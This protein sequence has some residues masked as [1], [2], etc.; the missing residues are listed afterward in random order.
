[1]GLSLRACA[2]TFALCSLCGG[3]WKLDKCAEFVYVPLPTII[4]LKQVLLY[5]FPDLCKER[6]LPHPT[7]TVFR[8]HLLPL[9][10]PDEAELAGLSNNRESPHWYAQTH[11]TGGLSSN[12]LTD[13]LLWTS[14]L[15]S[16]SGFVH[17]PGGWGRGV[18]FLFLDLGGHSNKM[19]YIS[20]AETDSFSSTS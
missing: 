3:R 11:L 2:H 15:A 14:N 10:Q 18:N 5:S 17:D 7:P 19:K 8:F 6:V 9:L 4:I 20:S 16:V 12:C 13:S 1:V